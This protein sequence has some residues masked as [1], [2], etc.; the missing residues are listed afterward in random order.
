[1][2]AA[3]YGCSLLGSRSNPRWDKKGLLCFSVETFSLES[4]TKEVHV[5]PSWFGAI[6]GFKANGFA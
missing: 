3:L 2:L 1:M 5:I 4:R 6:G